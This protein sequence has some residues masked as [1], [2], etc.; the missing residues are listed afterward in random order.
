MVLSTW[1]YEADPPGGTYR[2]ARADGAWAEILYTPVGAG[3]PCS[4]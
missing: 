2:A 3:T 1:F 4:A